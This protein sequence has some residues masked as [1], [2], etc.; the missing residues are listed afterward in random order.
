MTKWHVYSFKLVDA[1]RPLHKQTP[2]HCEAVCIDPPGYPKV[3]RVAAS[4]PEK[5]KELLIEQIKE[6]L[7]HSE[8]IE[9]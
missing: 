7:K 8:I 2:Y 1:Y 9:I 5:A 3:A 6:Y 4:T